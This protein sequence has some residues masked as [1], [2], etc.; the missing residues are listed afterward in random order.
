TNYTVYQKRRVNNNPNTIL[1]R[2]KKVPK[3]MEFIF[4]RGGG[5]SP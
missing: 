4:T 3:D 5:W 2:I 1:I